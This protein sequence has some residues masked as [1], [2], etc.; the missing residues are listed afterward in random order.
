MSKWEE[1]MSIINEI[2]SKQNITVDAKNCLN[3]LL[4]HS[5]LN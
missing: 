4:L 3:D 5:K 1:M 2:S